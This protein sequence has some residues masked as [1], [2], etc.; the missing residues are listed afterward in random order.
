MVSLTDK[1]MRL[2][3]RNVKCFVLVMLV[4]IQ[5]IQKIKRVHRAAFNKVIIFKSLFLINTN[6]CK[7][8]WL[9]PMTIKKHNENLRRIIF[10]LF[11]FLIYFCYNYWKIYALNY[12]LSLF[13]LSIWIEI[14]Y[15][16]LICKKK[17]N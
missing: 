5:R 17:K 7:C 2:V 16:F 14:K 11:F 12:S 8:C 1:C 13:F 10:D 3:T 9:N 6:I 4:L 15:N